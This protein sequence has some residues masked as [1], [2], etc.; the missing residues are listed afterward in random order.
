[1]K[2]KILCLFFVCVLLGYIPVKSQTYQP[3]LYFTT[4]EMPNLLHCLPAPPDTNSSAF[5]H[6]I[7]RY[8]WGK[9]QRLDTARTAIARRD[10]VWN[11]DSLLAEFSVP[12]GIEISM[13]TCPEIYKFL[14]NSISTV[15][16]IRVLPKAFY[17]RKRPFVRFQEHLLTI[18]E[19]V[20]LKNEGSYPSGHAIR[21]WTVA[22]LLS[23]LNPANTDTIMARGFMYGESRVI[24]GAHWQ[25]DVDASRLGA[26]IGV[27]RL[28]TSE[29]FLK[30]LHKAQKEF[31]QMQKQQG[32]TKRK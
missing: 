4:E 22:L 7:M 1:M 5:V 3:T 18:E 13:E 31:Q 24:V 32:T 20:Y 23:E 16:Q 9:T 6:D 27:A 11:L 2:N 30:H 10:A 28:H 19:E 26:A 12:F 21:G 17:M 25:S 14:I 15:E 8:M 29:E